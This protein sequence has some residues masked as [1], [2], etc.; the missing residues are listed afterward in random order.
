MTAPRWRV[1]AGAL[2]PLAPGVALVFGPVD[3]G[4]AVVVLLVT[5]LAACWLGGVTGGA[6][7]GV[8]ATFLY[9]LAVLPPRLALKVNPRSL[10]H[11]MGFAL[12]VVLVLALRWALMRADRARLVAERQARVLAERVDRLAPLLDGAPIG[13]AL[14]DTDLRYR[15]VNPCLAEINGL[16]VADHLGHRP[17]EVLPAGRGAAIEARVR[18]VL[19]SGTA[20]DDNPVTVAGPGGDRH[21]RGSRYPIRD[22][23]GALVGVAVSVVETTAQARLQQ[24]LSS[25]LAELTATVQSSPLAIALVDEQLRYKRVNRVFQELGAS[26]AR[27]LVG[28]RVAD[29]GRLP[30][31]VAAM[32][33]QVLD[34]G[35]SSGAADILVPATAEAAERHLAASCFPVRLE[36]GQ[37][38]AIGLVLLDTTE[39]HRAAQL[40][41]EAEALRAT[42][43]MAFRLEEVQRLAGFGS[44]EMDLGT[45]EITWSKQMRAIAGE[46]DRYVTGGAAAIVHPDDV[47]RAAAHRRRLV[48]D[49]VPYAD[50]FRL[51]RP[52]GSTIDVYGTGE[53]VR[54]DDG[55]PVRVWGTLQ[56]IT[57]RRDAERAAQEAQNREANARAQ[58]AAE[59]DALQMFLRAMLPAS[60]PDV[61]GARLSAAYL[62]VVQR[63]DIGGDWY[64]AFQLPDGCLALTVG[65]VTGHDLR[66]ATVM[67]QVRNAVRAY[68]LEDPAPGSVLQ[69]IN[70]LLN[71]VPDLDLVTMVMAVYDPGTG[72]LTWANAGHPPPVLRTADGRV[73]LLDQP[74][75]LLLGVLE[76][77]AY[78]C[79]QVGLAPGDTVLWYTDGLVDQRTLDPSAAT[80][81]LTG[82]VAATGGTGGELLTAIGAQMLDGGDHE[83][84]VCLLVLHRDAV[85]ASV[86]GSGQ[87]PQPVQAQ[88]ELHLQ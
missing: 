36:S 63:V 57:V 12:A 49:S 18:E 13:F 61:P 32:C 21:F 28:Q 53:A 85:P 23:A 26:S 76:D 2:L 66:A 64:D 62:P 38:V 55:Q 78:G 19:D 88:R 87:L 31:L 52:D 17:T 24:Q 3:E 45:G 60:L 69:R 81:T 30:P 15:Y 82:V 35:R 56:D 25:A 10:P 16:P 84:D 77:E 41:A 50:E 40:A 37:I 70:R 72:A 47:E 67:G 20:Q 33:R 73:R 43:E 71:R 22:D 75:G 48:D 86:D 42:A 4:A 59:H 44:W 29:A 51:V 80:R 8:L 54:D 5:V 34:S 11:L 74:G 65:D 46:P 14:V 9:D 68:A 6:A 79:A 58:L 27:D 83:D 39:R 7:A 1:A